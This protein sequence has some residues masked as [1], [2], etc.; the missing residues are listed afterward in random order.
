MDL[1]VHID[2]LVIDH[3]GADLAAALA[4]ALCPRAGG[5]LDAQALASVGR[6][7]AGAVRSQG[8]LMRSSDLHGLAT[9]DRLNGGPKP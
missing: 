3:G 4:D 2:E 5:V 1:T 7:V 6:A 9:A 8:A